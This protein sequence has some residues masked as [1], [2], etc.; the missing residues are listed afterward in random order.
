MLSIAKRTTIG[1]LLLLILPVVTIL[2]GWEWRPETAFLGLKGLFWLTETVTRPW[3]IM[4]HFILFIVFIWCLR[5]RLKAA[6]ML[7][8][9]LSVAIIGGQT[10]KS[11]IKQR[12]QEPRP[13]VVWLE[14]S[15]G[16]KTAQFYH[17]DRK[18]RGAIVDKQLQGDTHLPVWLRNHWR[19]ETGFAFP[20]GHTLFAASWALLGVG[21]LWPRRRIVLVGI[22]ML[23]AGGVMASRMVLGMHWPRHLIVAALISWLLV[24]F[25]CWLTQRWCGS[26]APPR[27]EQREIASRSQSGE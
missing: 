10:V 17:M 24:T 25:A 3:G 16:I 11:F 21:L 4:T 27:E 13:F 9:I 22:L 23:W 1:M 20:S 7:F 19:K 26:L 5:F 12:V 2:S 8:A 15:H 18:M 14:K 6:L